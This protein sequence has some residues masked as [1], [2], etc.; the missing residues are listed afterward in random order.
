M[1]NSI[2]AKLKAEGVLKLYHDYRAGHCNDLSGNGNNGTLTGCTLNPNGLAVG[3]GTDKVTIADN[4]TMGITTGSIIVFSLNLKHNSAT[5]GVY[6]EKR[7]SAAG[8]KFYTVTADTTFGIY[9][10][11]TASVVTSQ[12]TNKKYIAANINAAGTK[13]DFYVDGI[14]VGQGNNNETVNATT[15]A[16]TIG[17][18]SSATGVMQ[19][20]SAVLLTSRVLTATEH[21]Q[22]YAELS[23]MKWPTKPFT[24][25]SKP[26]DNLIADGDMEA[27]GVTAWTAGGVNPVLSKQTGSP[28]NGLQCLRIANTGAGDAWASANQAVL[29][30]GKRYRITG[31]ARGD[32]S[33]SPG[34]GTEL[35]F[36]DIWYGTSSTSWQYIDV[37]FSPKQGT[38]R[39]YKLTAGIGYSEFDD[40]RLVEIPPRTNL[41]IHLEGSPISVAARG[42]AIGQ[43]LETT[44]LQFGDATGRYSVST[45]TVFGKANTKVISC[46]TAGLLYM[47]STQAYGTWEFDIYKGGDGGSLLLG[48]ANGVIGG[49]N[50]V[51]QTGM[52]FGI[53]SDESIG[54]LIG[55][56][57]SMRTTASYVS[58]N[59]WYKI[60]ITRTSAGVI[61]LWIRG[62]IYSGWTLVDLTGGTG[63]NPVTNTSFSTANYMNLTSGNSGDKIANV[64]FK[65]LA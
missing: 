35:S 56:G 23:K 15:Q 38:L 17:Q 4:A 10:G 6:Y 29:R 65:P 2:I 46:S 28:F 39:L 20:L 34:I 26:N 53:I 61:T 19:T 33:K 60:K 54:I 1:K 62:G 44:P 43:Y 32:G 36:S 3:S 18:G 30:V 16:A 7:L 24:K 58:N 27:S 13:P 22:L 31:K 8:F 21:A 40:M 41:N 49:W 12:L 59:T 64:T 14:Y 25:A 63:T 55:G 50:A 48:V 9:D 5:T 11:L 51:G 52:T 47:P 42:G 57:Y 45:D 37:E